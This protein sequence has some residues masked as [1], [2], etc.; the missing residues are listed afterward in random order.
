MNLRLSGLL[1][2]GMCIFLHPL[3]VFAAEKELPGVTAPS[4]MYFVK[5]GLALLLVLGLFL[6]FAWMMRRF[7][8]MQ[9]PARG[10]L[11]VITGLSLGTRERLVVVKAGKTQLLLGITPGQI[12][13]LHVLD[14]DLEAELTS[15][16]S[17]FKQKLKTALGHKET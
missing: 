14:E 15:G 11:R 16:Q 4:A 5:L 8:G 12:R 13:K 10:G 7:N 2:T 3:A 6:A 17:D 1:G 9:S